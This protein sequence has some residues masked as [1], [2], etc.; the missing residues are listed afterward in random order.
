MRF[1]DFYSNKN[2]WKGLMLIL[3]ILI[4][5]ATL[6]Y[7]ETFLSKL[8]KEEVKKMEVWAES[9]QTSIAE[10]VGDSEL[11]L[12]NLV[13]QTN[14]TIPIVM[15]DGNGNIQTRRN[16]PDAYNDSPKALD[17]YI[18]KLMDK[19]QPIVIQFAQGDPLFVYFDDSVL[20]TQ[21]R[22]YPRVLL[23]VI[24]S[25]LVIAYVTFSS[26]RRAEQDRVWTGLAKE[27]AHQIGTPLSSLMG[28]V[29]ILRSKGVEDEI[30]VEIEKDIDRLTRITDRF[31]KIG[32]IPQ[33][34]PICVYDGVKDIVDY[35]QPRV[36]RK[37]SLMFTAPER[38]R[39]VKAPLNLPLFQWVVENLI[40]NGIDSIQGK[41]EVKVL[42]GEQPS[43][44]FIEVL[45]TGKGIPLS[46]QSAVFRPGYTTKSRGWG[47]GLSLSRRIINDYH[48]G[49]IFVAQSEIGKGSVFRIQLKKDA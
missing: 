11:T 10:D 15:V 2:V 32:S 6:I 7:T 31:S 49:K 46:Q 26:S 45:D 18:Q 47:L 37:I 12:A 24:A 21:L 48:K 3:A 36:P 1:P 5:V 29:E 27:T 4:G 13:L 40:R 39:H 22:I 17:G 43:Y 16:I 14:T 33:L 41:G 8:R 42:L 20:L 34:K 38:L 30:I 28:W 44:Y 19:R 9:L 25:F 35:L 23:G